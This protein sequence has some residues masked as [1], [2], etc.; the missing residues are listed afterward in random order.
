MTIEKVKMFS[1]RKINPTFI[2]DAIKQAE[3]EE[4]Q[5]KNKFDKYIE[6]TKIDKLSAIPVIRKLNF[7]D[8]NNTLTNNIN[9]EAG[10]IRGGLEVVNEESKKEKTLQMK[11]N[12]KELERYHFLR[13]Y[14]ENRFMKIM[15]LRKDKGQ[16]PEPGRYHP[17]FNCIRERVPNVIFDRPLYSP[18]AKSEENEIHKNF[19]NILGEKAASI[20]S[21]QTVKN[22]TKNELTKIIPSV[23]TVKSFDNSKPDHFLTSFK[24]LNNSSSN[25][26]NSSSNNNS[27]NN[28]NRNK[29]ESGKYLKA[30][31]NKSQSEKNLLFNH[32]IQSVYFKKMTGRKSAKILGD[33]PTTGTYNPNYSYVTKNAKCVLFDG[34]KSRDPSHFKK[35]IVKKVIHSYSVSEDYSII[36]LKRESKLQEK[37]K[38]NSNN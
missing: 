14:N 31:L 19:T 1:T 7:K 15:K 5:I 23:Q 25:N 29:R 4:E 8:I 20:N 34:T 6:I 24:I 22:K 16:V 28:S 2:D 17:N 35:A 37:K 38:K 10:L 11:K 32:R 26:N 27:S 3:R 9:Y 36:K 13:R 18:T 33:G 21:V 12:E 30:F